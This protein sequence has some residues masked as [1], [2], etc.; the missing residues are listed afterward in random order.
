MHDKG[1]PP[2]GVRGEIFAHPDLAYRVN[3]A[4]VSSKNNNDYA[5]YSEI[6]SADTAQK[7]PE[8][9]DI[10]TKVAPSLPEM[11]QA[12]LRPILGMLRSSGDPSCAAT[13]SKK[14]DALP[15]DHD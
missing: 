5:A 11:R 12:D 4:S 13:V 9:T 15:P 2:Q 7:A 8:R 10:E 1:S 3:N 14:A 6:Q